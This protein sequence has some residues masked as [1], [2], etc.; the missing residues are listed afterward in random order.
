M[1]KR[2]SSMYKQQSTWLRTLL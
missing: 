2:A 1:S